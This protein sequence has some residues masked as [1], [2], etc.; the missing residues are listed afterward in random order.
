MTSPEVGEEIRS[1]IDDDRTR[2]WRSY[3]AKFEDSAVKPGTAH[4]SLIDSAGNVVAVTS[5][6][7]L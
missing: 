4:F 5:T 1:K 7:N 6:I 3:G 2:D